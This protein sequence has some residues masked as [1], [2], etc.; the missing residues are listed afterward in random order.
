VRAL[1]C[2]N[3]RRDPN[4]IQVDR[5]A[6][7]VMRNKPSVDFC[8]CWQRSLASYEQTLD[9]VNLTLPPQCQNQSQCLRE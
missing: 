9:N 5:V 7:L 8:G 4:G 3:H 6:T 1:G 2:E